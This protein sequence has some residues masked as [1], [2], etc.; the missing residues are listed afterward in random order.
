MLD[1]PAFLV[2]EVGTGPSPVQVFWAREAEVELS[3]DEPAVLLRPSWEV[4]KD[5]GSLARLEAET[6][7][8]ECCTEGGT[9]EESW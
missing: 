6:G 3:S 2:T 1:S 7:A 9:L 8:A 4:C 5:S